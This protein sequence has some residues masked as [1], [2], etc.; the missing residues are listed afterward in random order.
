[1]SEGGPETRDDVETGTD[2]A[3]ADESEPLL[4][5]NAEKKPLQSRTSYD[6]Y[7]V[8]NAGVF[9]YICCYLVILIPFIYGFVVA[10]RN[11]ADQTAPCVRE[12]NW[13][14]VL[15]LCMMINFVFVLL[16]FVHVK[17]GTALISLNYFFIFVWYIYGAYIFFLNPACSIG[18]VHMFGKVF[19]VLFLI[20]VGII[21]LRV[22]LNNAFEVKTA[23]LR[24]VTDH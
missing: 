6:P 22:S 15:S 18:E 13:V 20:S 10:L 11:R 8:A 14:L 4:S 1:M 3:V 17:A 24:Y 9:G 21:F 2:K 19:V 12:V 7:I 23:A 5:K 16:Y